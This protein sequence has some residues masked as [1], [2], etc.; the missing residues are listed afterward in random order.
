MKLGD[1]TLLGSIHIRRMRTLERGFISMVSI[2]LCMIV[3]NEEK[4]IG[5]CLE[6]VKDIVDEINIVDTGST[7]KTVEVVQ[8]HTDRIFHFKWIHDFAAARNYSFQQATKDYI[9][10]LDADDVIH[11]EDR[12]KFLKLKQNLSH[13]VDSVSMEYQLAFD[14]QGKVL[15][16]LRRN[17]LVKRACNFKWIGAVHEYL[18]VYG[19]MEHGEVA[20]QHRPIEHDANRNIEIYEAM[21]KRGATFT[22][23]DLFYYG[24]ECKDHQHYSRAIQQ[25]HRFLETE[26]GWVEDNIR[27]C[28]HIAECYNVLGLPKQGIEWILK[29]FQYDR[30]RAEAACRLGYFFLE[31]NQFDQAIYWYQFATEYRA[32]SNQMAVEDKS[33]ST[34]FPHLQLCVCYDRIGDFENSYKHN[35]IAHKYQPDNPHV[36]H[37]KSYLENK[38][39]MK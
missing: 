13:T 4:V 9:L 25:Y 19:N 31:K 5:R 6:S 15:T 12:K 16:C 21:E 3:K 38:L 27:A 11:T 17:R 14:S 34:W 2:S 30:P 7:D 24:N 20:I 10:W 22:P 28:Y 29:T 33:F 18:E 37:N 36:L 32:P 23:R 35:E 8:Q 1:L 39:Q 26:Q